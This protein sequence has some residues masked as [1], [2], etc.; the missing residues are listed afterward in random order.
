MAKSIKCK[1]YT[2]TRWGSKQYGGSYDSKAE[3]YKQARFLCKH[4]Y[5]SSYQITAT[6]G[7][8][9]FRKGTF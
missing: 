4:G 3:A 8:S 9:I 7:K 1:L 6:D 2:F 5:A